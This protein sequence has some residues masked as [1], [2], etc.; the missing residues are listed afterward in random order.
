MDP[1]DKRLAIMVDDHEL[2]Y[3]GFE[4]TIPEGE[5]GAGR[6]A[7]WDRGEFT[8]DS[9]GIEEGKMEIEVRGEKL[10]GTFALVRMKGKP[11]EWLLIKKRDGLEKPGFEL[12]TVLKR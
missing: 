12:D 10:M 6:V 1:K 8:L 4:G 7:V 3:A 5:Y 11:K 2:D 9:G